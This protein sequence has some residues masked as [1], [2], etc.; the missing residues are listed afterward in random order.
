MKMNS[1]K[2]TYLGDNKPTTALMSFSL[3]DDITF[4]DVRK[5]AD[6]KLK[7]TFVARFNKDVEPEEVSTVKTIER[8]LISS[9]IDDEGLI[10]ITK[11]NGKNS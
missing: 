6:T 5:I 3:S 1:F 2:I 11:Y 10:K 7:I 8:L 4:V 9:D